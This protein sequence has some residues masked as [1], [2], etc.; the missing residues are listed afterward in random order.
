M[1]KP[2]SEPL[3]CRGATAIERL[4]R[5]LFEDAINAG[6]L[7]SRSFKP[8]KNRNKASVFYAMEDILGVERRILNGE[9]PIAKKQKVTTTK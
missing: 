7:V 4:G 5:A 3:I 2:K 9:Y 8:G 6:W 1:E